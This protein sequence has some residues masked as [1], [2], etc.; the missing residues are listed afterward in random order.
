MPSFKTQ[1]QRGHAPAS[2]G[3]TQ[4]QLELEQLDICSLHLHGRPG[5]ASL[6]L[7]LSLPLGPRSPSLSV[8][9]ACADCLTS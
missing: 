4:L 3:L 9:T 1:L 7:S 2:D 8:E 6:S 5:W